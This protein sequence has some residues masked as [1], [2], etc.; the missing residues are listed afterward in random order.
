MFIRDHG[1]KFFHPRPCPHSLARNVRVKCSPQP[2]RTKKSSQCCGSGMFIRDPGYKFYPSQALSALPGQE[3]ARQMLSTTWPNNKSSQCCQVLAALPG[4]ECV[5]QMLSTTWPNKKVVSVARSCP[6]SRA[7]NV[8]VKC[9]PQ[10][11]RTKKSN[12][13]SGSGMFIR[14]P[15]Y[16]FSIPGPVR[17]PSPGM[18]ASNA[19]HNLPEQK[20]SQCCQA[21]YTLPRQE[22][23]RQMLSTTCPNKKK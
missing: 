20:S 9:S 13:C 17:T 5:C 6:H 21:L 2:V 14:D 23:A 4:Q 11:A 8:R 3:C 7:R 19:L 18:C 10:P 12:Q 1:S 15:G 16:K 22:C